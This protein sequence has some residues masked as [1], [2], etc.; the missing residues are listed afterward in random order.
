MKDFFPIFLSFMMFPQKPGKKVVKR[1]EN[2]KKRE[3]RLIGEIRR[4]VRAVAS[5]GL[6]RN[7]DKAPQWAEHTAKRADVPA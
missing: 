4:S 6:R 3:D 1:G 5:S 2:A 7:A